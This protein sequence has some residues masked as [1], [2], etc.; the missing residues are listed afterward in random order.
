M[1]RVLG[2]DESQLSPA[3]PP[4]ALQPPLPPPAVGRVTGSTPTNSHLVASQSG[5]MAHEVW[6]P[7]VDKDQVAGM[8]NAHM[9]IDQIN[10][11]QAR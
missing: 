7:P 5:G 3:E 1:L 4:A 9:A 10:T 8:L 2:Q 6:A 11:P